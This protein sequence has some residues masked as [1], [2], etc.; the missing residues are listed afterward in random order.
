MQQIFN[1]GIVIIGEGAAIDNSQVK[2]V[3][4]KTGEVSQVGEWYEKY[5]PVVFKHAAYLTGSL[6]DAGDIAQEVFVR[7]LKTPPTHSNVQAWLVKVATHLAYNHLRNQK[8]KRSQ[9]PVEDCEAANVISIE[10][11]AIKNVEILI[12]KKVLEML[13]YR[14][15]MC[16]LLKF[17]GYKYH[18]IAAVLTIEKASV[19][20]ILARA[21]EKFKALY[22]K[23]ARER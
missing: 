19:G 17:S 1:W 20:K 16:L 8:G 2:P 13:N 22:L 3:R 23:E 6:N 5:Y 10:D 9:T 15:R 21:Q 7:L 14:E 18:E 12:T 4:E 11:L